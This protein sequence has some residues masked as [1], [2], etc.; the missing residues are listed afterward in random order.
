L[1][2]AILV[3]FSIALFSSCGI[4]ATNETQEAGNTT[5]LT[6]EQATSTITN[7]S[8]NETS[9]DALKSTSNENTTNISNSS[10]SNSTTSTNKSTVNSTAAA[11]GNNYSNVHG[12][13]VNTD[14]AL[15][16][17]VTALKNEG[18]TDIFVKCNIYSSP[19]YKTILT[20]IV[21]MF[22]GSG[23]RV[24]A[25]VTCFL[26]ANGN[27]I[28]PAGTTYTYTVKVTKKVAVKTPYKSWYKHWYKSWYK[29]WYKSWYKFKKHWYYKWKYTWKYTWKYAW[30]YV[31]KT[32][33]TYKTVTTTQTKTGINTTHNDQVVNAI[34]DMVKNYGVD[35]VNL[36]YIRYPGTAYKYS[37]GT[38]T[39]TSFVK[40]VYNSV[41]A[42]N[43][44]AAVSADL[45]PEGS[46]NAYYY[47]QDYAQLAKYL[48]FI[49]PMVYK[50]NYGYNSSVGTSSSGKNG[51]D[52]IGSA[53]S[54]IVSKSGD[55]PVV[56]G[57]QT[58]RSDKNV[59]AI[60]AS[61]LQNDID[62]AINNGSSGYVLFRYGLI[63][64]NFLYNPTT[65][66]QD[67]NT[68]DN[69]NSSSTVI[70]KFTIKQ[71]QN[72]SASVKSFIESNNRLPNYV[73]IGTSQVTMAQ[74]LQ[75]LATSLLQ[76]NSGTSTSIS[77][78][79]INSPANSTGDYIYGN[80]NKTEYL[81][82]AKNI[83]TF[84]DS[85]KVAPT[86]ASSSLGKVQYETLI[87]MFSKILNY[88]NTNGRLPNY[89]SVD[90]TV[91][92]PESYSIPSSLQQYLQATTNCQVTSSSIKS[93]A[94]SITSSKTSVYDKAVAIFNWVRDN[95]GYSFY[96]N[97]KYG[98]VGTLNAKTGN[99]VDTTHLLIALE[100][101]AGIPARYEHVYAQF[102]SGNWYGH[103]IAQVYVNGKWYNADATSS[104]N[105]FGVIKNWNTATATYYGTYAT[106]PF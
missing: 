24:N 25:W 79:N 71:I 105:T 78:G 53:I 17:N 35:G 85:N 83:K 62:A 98:A 58:Y 10:T 106:L 86:Y 84:I 81:S 23:I 63:D 7:S 20:K 102:S 99:C 16:L 73:T 41:K 75:L 21:N 80:I 104:S 68:T 97:T 43:K 61:E 37:N 48:D 66:E 34:V 46:A 69:T 27:W 50:G 28:N 42:V 56:A 91:A 87:Y 40:R 90:S 101:A 6:I 12:I 93:L 54:Y 95:I 13:W 76:I 26:D 51:T 33:T 4:Y 31:W 3:I 49:V 19:T 45:M 92:N 18:I 2:L 103:V 89:V 82:I 60:P 15:K 9:T 8:T 29:H 96:Y 77:L 36:D 5:N 70:T 55:T 59:T 47:G 44:Q 39:I 32:K 72:A 1:F 100:R 11:G 38:A 30:K 22:K 94:A 64:K 14:D 74:F 57:L 65:S 67:S 88:Y 52:W